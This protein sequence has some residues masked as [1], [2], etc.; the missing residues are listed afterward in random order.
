MTIFLNGNQIKPIGSFEI[1]NA[2]GDLLDE[3]TGEF[4]EHGNDSWAYDQRGFDYITR[5]Q[6]GYNYAIRNE[7]LEK[8]I[9]KI[10]KG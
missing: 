9:E 10:I 5:D 7:I 6:H 3:A 8:K 4:N 1:F 2:Q